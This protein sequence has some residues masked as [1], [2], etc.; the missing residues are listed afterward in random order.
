MYFKRLDFNNNHQTYTSRTSVL[1]LNDYSKAFKIIINISV[2]FSIRLYRNHTKKVRYAA[3]AYRTFKHYL[4]SLFYIKL[5]TS[6]WWVSLLDASI[7]SQ[8][9]YKPYQSLLQ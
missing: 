8:L 2:N 7:T 6:G 3:I 9:K 4:N 1:K 5:Y